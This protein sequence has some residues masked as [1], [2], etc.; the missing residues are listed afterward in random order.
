VR[1]ESVWRLAAVVLVFA[2]TAA[3]HE[4]KQGKKRDATK[5]ADAAAVTPRLEK[6][7]VALDLLS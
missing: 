4:R 3:R 2:R 7:R 1:C 5:I 6:V